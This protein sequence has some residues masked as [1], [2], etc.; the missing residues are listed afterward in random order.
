[1]ANMLL[2]PLEGYLIL[3]EKVHLA[4]DSV[5]KDGF[6]F[7]PE[8]ADVHSVAHLAD[9]MIRHWP[10]RWIDASDPT[11]VHE[12]GRLNL[13]IDKARSELDWA[14]VWRFEDAI[15]KTV[16]WYHQVENGVDPIDLTQAQIAAFEAAK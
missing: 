7:G 11:A 1:M 10:G 5:H 3:A 4:S 2:D 9:A 16:H 13:S 15:E 6:N 8:P 14:P 12:A